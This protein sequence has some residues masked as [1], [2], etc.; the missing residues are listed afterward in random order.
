MLLDLSW[1][2]Y[3]RIFSMK[4]FHL[5]LRVLHTFGLL[6]NIL[7]LRAA[8]SFHKVRKFFHRLIPSSHLLHVRNDLALD[9]PFY[10]AL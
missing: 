4:R 3:L 6:P 2:R 7:I 10:L 9:N 1:A 5:F 8:F